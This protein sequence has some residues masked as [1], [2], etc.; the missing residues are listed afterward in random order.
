LTRINSESLNDFLWGIVNFHAGGEGEVGDDLRP[1]D[2][3]RVKSGGPNM[4]VKAVAPDGITGEPT[5]WCEWFDKNH[6]SQ[7]GTFSPSVLERL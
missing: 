7:K 1:G 5:V 3:V 6:K 4:T 2:V